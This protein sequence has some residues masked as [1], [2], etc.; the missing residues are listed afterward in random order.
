MIAFLAKKLIADHKNIKDDRVR[1]AYGN[2][3]SVVG[4]L[5]NVLLCLIKFTAGALSG[6]VSI[7]ADAVNNLSDAG[8]S[9]ISLISFFLSSRPADE[10]HPFGHA[11]YECIASMAVACLIFLL[12]LELMKTSVSKILHPQEVSFSL[13][14]A[15][16]LLCSIAVKLWMYCY[17]RHYGRLLRSSV[18]EA[19]AADSISDVLATGAVL[20]SFVLSPLLHFNLDGYMGV[21]VACL[22]MLAGAGILRSALD[23]LLGKAPEK[24]L[25]KELMEQIT[26]HDGVL[27]AHDLVVHDYGVNRLF[28][29]VHVEVDCRVDVMKS[30][31][32]IDNIEREIKE[33]L[34]VELVIHMDPIR[35][36]DPLTNELKA[37]MKEALKEIHPA[38]SLHDFRVVSGETHT[39]LVFDVVVPHR[40]ELNNDQILEMLKEAVK[41]SYSFCYL[42]VTFDREYTSDFC[43]EEEQKEI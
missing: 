32:M 37:F 27:G 21:I 2:L 13:L 42:V 22:I 17:N 26:A 18:M 41:R 16:I 35:T 6:S 15:A 7:T 4:I 12:G 39:N 29:S 28:A 11:R 9:L 40:V 23:E 10:K 3:L 43:E 14:S 24:E 30:H 38:L 33:G 31:D 5:N 25:V 19:A 20:L 36:D 34:G 1:Q 8:S